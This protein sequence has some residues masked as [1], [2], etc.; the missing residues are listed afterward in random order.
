MAAL[1]QPTRRD[2]LALVA[3]GLMGALTGPATAAP[4]GTFTVASHVSLAPVWFDPSE[5]GGV[6]TAYMLI[7]GMHDALLKPTPDDP[8]APGL[9]ERHEVSADGLTHEFVLRDGLSFH[10]GDPL[11]SDDAKFSFARYHGHAAKLMHDAMAAVETPD[12][13]R[14]VFRLKEPW[15]DFMTFFVAA[16]GAGWVL[17][18]KYIERIGDV[19]YR[20]APVGA[21]PFKFISFDPGNDLVLEAFDG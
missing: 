3:A 13:R 19:G 17:P 5:S 12:R 7:Y 18:R 20:K 2:S 14:I 11:T 16:T 8:W 15:P 21:G 4:M 9:A 10:N 1:G 6:P